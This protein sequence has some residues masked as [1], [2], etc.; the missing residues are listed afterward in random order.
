MRERVGGFG[1]R[2]AWNKHRRPLVERALRERCA[3]P[4]EVRASLIER[5]GNIVH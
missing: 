1:G 3:I 4:P 5:L 2:N